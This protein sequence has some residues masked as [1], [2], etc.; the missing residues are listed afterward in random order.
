ML[1][2]QEVVYMQINGVNEFLSRIASLNG[3]GGVRG[4]AFLPAL[5]PNGQ[6]GHDNLFHSDIG[7]RLSFK[8]EKTPFLNGS[9]KSDAT[10][11][12]LVAIGNQISKVEAVLEK[13]QELATRAAEDKSL[14]ELERM[15]MQIEMEELRGE[16]NGRG[17]YTTEQRLR[18]D[19]NIAFLRSDNLDG[20]RYGDDTSLLGRARDRLVRGEKWDVKEAF[21]PFDIYDKIPAPDHDKEPLGEFITVSNGFSYYE[22]KPLIEGGQWIVIED[23]SIA[24]AEQILTVREQLER[25]NSIIL[26]DAKSAA[27]GVKRLEGEIEAAQKLRVKYTEFVNSEKSKDKGS[28]EAFATMAKEVYAK[29]A[30]GFNATLYSKTS[31]S[32][33]EP[34]DYPSFFYLG[35]DDVFGLPDRVIK[36]HNIGEYFTERWYSLV[37]RF[38]PDESK[39]INIYPETSK[40]NPPTEINLDIVA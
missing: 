22:P 14:T 26:M 11:P 25:G 6:A 12:I 9:Q 15:D 29:I 34:T 8:T 40:Q 24:N 38:K 19:K 17:R 4:N 13:M 5:V 16:L 20:W 37:D 23:E 7:K 30:E 18:R 2:Q 10:D 35:A 36:S 1:E 39:D 27:E 28:V 31:P 3:A 32:P 21:V 33:I